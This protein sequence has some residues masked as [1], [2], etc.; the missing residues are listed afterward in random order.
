MGMKPELSTRS[1]SISTRTHGASVGY[2]KAR[3]SCK[4][5]YYAYILTAG[6]LHSCMI[7][8]TKAPDGKGFEAP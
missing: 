5:T 8:S 7:N 4:S 1:M 2:W 6:A 3:Y